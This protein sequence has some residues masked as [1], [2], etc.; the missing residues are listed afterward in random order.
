MKY[1]H[2]K[3]FWET[4]LKRNYLTAE[5]IHT[6]LRRQLGYNFIKTYNHAQIENDTIN[7]LIENNYST[8]DIR[9]LVDTQGA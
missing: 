6:Y 2:T 1:K 4:W 9:I 7:Y 5:D 3:D 8:A